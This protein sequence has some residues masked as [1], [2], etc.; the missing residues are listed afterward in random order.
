M[1]QRSDLFT[2]ETSENVPTISGSPPEQWVDLYGNYLYSFALTRLRD[3]AAAQDAVQE[4]FLAALKARET[5]SGRSSERTWLVGILKHKIIDMF[6]KRSREIPESEA[7]LP[8]EQEEL[9]RE[10]GDEW[11]GHWKSEY[12]PADWGN[13]PLAAAERN[14]FQRVFRSCFQ[15]L[16]QR[17]ALAF[18]MKEIDDADCA[19][20]CTALEIT[21]TNLWVM[22]HRARMHLRRCLEVRWFSSDGRKA[23]EL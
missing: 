13:T 5:F 1:A 22:L 18:S 14:D 15:K 9:F 3:D 12:K 7:L 10:E 21:E 17:V 6:R 20:I 11:Q 23:N 16:P 19:E 2:T 8:F 4:T